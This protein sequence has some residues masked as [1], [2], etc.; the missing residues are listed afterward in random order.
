MIIIFIIIIS[1]DNDSTDANYNKNN[2]INIPK[3]TKKNYG[4][5]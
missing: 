3:P 4:P 2:V 1:D 5:Q